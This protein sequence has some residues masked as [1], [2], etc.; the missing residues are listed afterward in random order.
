MQTSWNC[1]FRKMVNPAMIKG[2]SVKNMAI[3]VLIGALV[4]TNFRVA[5][6][7]TADMSVYIAIV[8]G[9]AWMAVEELE[10]KW[11]EKRP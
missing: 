8:S 3:A 6:L 11:K 2:F 4:V 9:A 1:T 7:S 5:G 10:I